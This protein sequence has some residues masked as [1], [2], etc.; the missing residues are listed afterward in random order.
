MVYR[1]IW[2]S[3]LTVSVLRPLLYVLGMGFGVG[4]LVD[5]GPQSD[6]ILDGLTYV[7]F[8]A[9]AVIP[10]T[11]MMVLANDSL[12]PIRGGFIWSRT[13]FAQAS[14]PLSSGDIVAGVGLWHLTKGALA[15]S[16]VALALILLP[17]V[18]SWGLVPAVGF[19][20]LTGAAFAAPLTCWAAWRDTDM[21]F[22]NINRFVIVPMFLF[23]GAFYPL[24]VLPTWLQWF[25]RATP[26]WH[27]IE[28][29]RGVVTGTL[30]LAPGVGHSAYLA[31][32]AVVGWA[33]ARRVFARRLGGG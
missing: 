27:G 2:L 25:S 15:S 4:T 3:N 21:S 28:L 32:W 29:C 5:R 9:P 19:G 18:R 14:S 30:T 12:W 10:T 23:S 11:A 20:A 17:D 16:G 22:A 7:Q 26:T 6:Q 24:D 1:R 33:L 13:F 31:L 8:F